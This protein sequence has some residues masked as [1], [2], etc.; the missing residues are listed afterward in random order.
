MK[1]VLRKR[2]LNLLLVFALVLVS[3]GGTFKISQAKAQTVGFREKTKKLKVGKSYQLKW[4]K[5]K[6]IKIKK[7]TFSKK[8][9]AVQVTKKGKVIAKKPGKATIFCK[10]TYQRKGSAKK[11]NKKVNCS[12]VVTGAKNTEESKKGKDAPQ[13]MAFPPANITPGGSGSTVTTAPDM[14]TSKPGGNDPSGQETPKPGESDPSGQET[15]TPGESD[16]SG[17]ETPKPGEFDP[18]GQVTPKPGESDPS[19]EEP[20]TPDDPAPIQPTTTKVPGAVDIEQSR[21]AFELV[22]KMGL[23]INLGNTMEAYCANAANT[24]Q[25]ETYW[26]QPVTTQAM[27]T[28]MKRAGFHS[29]R[30]PVSWSSMMSKDGKYTIDPRLLERVKTIIQYAFQE[31]MYVIINIHW[32]GQWWG[33]FGDKDSSVRD[34]AWARYEAFWTQIS[35]YYKDFSD[36]L[37][38]ESANEEL[39]ERL[40]DDWNMGSTQTG[41]LTTN[42]CYQTTNQINQKF[43]DIVRASGGNND[44]RFLLIAG[45]DTNIS[46]TCDSRYVMPTDT[47]PGHLLVS[48]HYYSP[49]VYCLVDKVD[50]SWGYSATWGTD[51]DKA[52]MKEELQTMKR[53]FVDRGYPVVIGEYGVSD[54][55]MDDNTFVRKEGRDLF[56]QTLCDYTL[57]N[58]M[59]PVLWDTGGVYNKTT[60]QVKNE[61]EA[62]NYLALEKQAAENEVYV[63]VSFTGEHYWSGTLKNSAYNQFVVSTDEASTFTVAGNGGCFV[64]NG[65]NWDI[66]QNP[67]VEI[68][69][70]GMTGADS[71]YS[72]FATQYAGGANWPYIDQA[73]LYEG[74]CSFQNTNRFELPTDRLSGNLYFSLN[75]D[76]FEGKVTIKVKNK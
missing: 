24:T 74:T 11:Y 65:I 17:Q 23:G 33:Q 68:S 47:T 53:T 25:L 13:P 60:C 43:V 55:R 75:G 42:E 62:A 46:K 34:Q 5:A 31:D 48:V 76:D 54:T 56:F 51:A 59:C 63:P 29:I 12:I 21:P 50:N 6:G 3:V 15:P 9:A 66:Y 26:G 14:N 8:G 52:A 41:V 45:F 30:I 10:V 58:G 72:R 18:S 37:I 36:H 35:A 69:F 28:G 57:N 44:N 20:T 1:H 22:H 67:V 27:I 71:C 64:L 16:P 2:I 40:N 39:G 4:K 38:F 70:E 73:D 61:T 49:A 19:G 7:K 32:D